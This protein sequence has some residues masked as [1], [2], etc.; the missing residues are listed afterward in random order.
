MLIPFEIKRVRNPDNSYNLL[1]VISVDH[2]IG[3]D[4]IQ[5]SL[6][7]MQNKYLELIKK[8]KNQIALIQ[9][10]RNNRSDPKLHWELGDILYCFLE[11]VEKHGFYFA[12]FSSTISR[13]TGL[14]QRYLNYHLSF[15]KEYRKKDINPKIK[16]WGYQELLDI[17]DRKIR[18]ICKSKLVSGE[19]KTREELRMFKKSIK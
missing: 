14:S 5:S 19:I 11:Y 7:E 16:M 8:C 3:E 17:S 9:K 12:N 6:G 18:E 1:A 4:N 2:A 10:N 15:R 13:D